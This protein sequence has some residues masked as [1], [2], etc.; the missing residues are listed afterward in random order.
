M[1]TQTRKGLV[2]EINWRKLNE[3]ENVSSRVA[4]KADEDGRVQL[5]VDEGMRGRFSQQ[6][7]V[8]EKV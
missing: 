5:F 8:G 2:E 4:I 6:V 3:F 1:D 7:V